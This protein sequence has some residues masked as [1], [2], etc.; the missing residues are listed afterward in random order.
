MEQKGLDR[1]TLVAFALIGV[2]MIGF[3]WWN[4]QN[5]PA[6]TPVEAQSTEVV[7]ET[8]AA[9]SIS[10]DTTAA[11]MAVVDTDTIEEQFITISNA[12]LELTFSTVGAQIAKARIGDYQTYDSLPLHLI[13][14]SSSLVY[15]SGEVSTGNYHY[16]ARQSQVDGNAVIEFTSLDAPKPISIVY[17]IPAEGYMI[18]TSVSGIQNGGNLKVDWI[19]ATLRQ[20]KNIDNERNATTISYLEGADDYDYLSETSDDSEDL[21]NLGWVAHKQ[22]FFSAILTPTSGSF[23]KASLDSKILTESDST[24]K[25]LTSR[26]EVSSQGGTST[27]DL[28]LGPNHF[29]TLESYGKQYEDIIPLGWGIFGWINKYIVIKVFNWLDQYGL[30]YGL[31]IFI[32]A[33]LI[34][35][36]LFPLT[37]T[38]YKSM[39]KMRVLK[40]EIDEINEKFK[41]KDP[42]KK[43][44]ATLELYQKAGVNPLGGCLPMLLQFPI[45]IAIFRFFPSSIELRQ[46][47]FL[48]ASDLS[49]YDSIYNLPF[50]IPFY[51]DHVSLFTLLM[52]V[53]TLIYTWMN[54][55]MTG[56]TQQMP[57]MKYIMYLMPIMFLGIFNN[58]ASGLS[59]YYF[60]SN[61]I[62]FG[63]Q[64][65]IRSMMNDEAIH[66][67]LQE[68]KK[69][70]KK[71]SRFAARLEEA[72]RQAQ[73][74]KKK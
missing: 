40:P 67:K 72:Q 23:S 29:Q 46:Q 63:Q 50:E 2:I 18:S 53:S 19:Q 47:G 64:W 26:L 31:I 10:Q 33:V 58:Y 4:G 5:A 14:N 20:E 6:E 69:K 56:S 25:A 73:S 52:T 68:N 59:Y 34:K 42:M 22:Q 51:G 57:Q 15:S 43:Q 3:Y 55:Q 7:E 48:W 17:T 16:A 9:S 12:D 38:S 28:Y 24:T 37:Y 71:K 62:T 44:Q 8:P 11:A 54:S 32:M 45:L 27:F 21:T 1:N 74:A 30:N 70:P 13:D 65:G 66:A 60:L 49:S 61:M 39:A 36:I 35:L 41:D